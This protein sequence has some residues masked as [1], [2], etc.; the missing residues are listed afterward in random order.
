MEEV[1][2]W[3]PESGDMPIVS[4]KHYNWKEAGALYRARVTKDQ[5]NDETFSVEAIKGEL[6][7]RELYHIKYEPTWNWTFVLG[8][9]ED[10]QY[11]KGDPFIFCDGGAQDSEDDRFFTEVSRKAGCYY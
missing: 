5:F 4:S 11:L 8:P 9:I 7:P 6:V 10:H 2:D 3:D 1:V